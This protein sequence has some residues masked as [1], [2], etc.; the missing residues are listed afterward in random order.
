MA[1]SFDSIT[2]KHFTKIGRR[3]WWKYVYTI[4]QRYENHEKFLM[5]H[6]S[7]Y[8]FT[9]MHFKEPQF[10]LEL[11]LLSQILKNCY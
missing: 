3:E 10:R 7:I 4:D 5:V 9:S 6:I 8:V 2:S 1:F 11:C